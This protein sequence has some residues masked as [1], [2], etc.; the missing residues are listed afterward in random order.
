MLHTIPLDELLAPSRG[1]ISVIGSGGKS[2]LLACGGEA[3]RRMGRTVVLATSTHMFA[4]DDMAL[5]RS[6]MELERALA[7]TGIACAG[8]I[9]ERTGKLV[10]PAMGFSRLAAIADHVLV[11]ADGSHRL[12]LKA[13]APHEPVFP[14][15]SE[16]AILVVGASGFGLPVER[17]VHRPE[18]FCRLAGCSPQEPATPELVARAIL[19]EGLV[20]E[21]DL[22]I[23]NQVDRTDRPGD[24][25]ACRAFARALDREVL[26]GGIRS[27]ALVRL[28]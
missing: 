7:A 18:A 3:L 9:E 23:V 12:P 26:A 8:E 16:R 22:V 17:A 25:D 6:E 27:G 4:P 15:Q 21:D 19:A 20:D 13:H 24:L 1:V 2:T 14:P 28:G 5:A 10:E 11:E